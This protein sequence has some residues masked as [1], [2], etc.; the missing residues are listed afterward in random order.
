MSLFFRRISVFGRFPFVRLIQVLEN[1]LYI[2]HILKKNLIYKRSK[3]DFI[4]KYSNFNFLSGQE[5]LEELIRSGKSLARFSD[6]E[7]EMITG[8]GIYPPDSNWSQ[9]WSSSLTQDLLTVLSSTD[10]HLL[11]AVDPPSTFLALRSST[12]SIPFEYNMWIDM[13]R[14]MWKFLSPKVSYGHSHLFIKANSPDFNWSQLRNYF[15]DKDIILAT[16]KVHTLSHLALGQRTFFVECGIKNSYERKEKIKTVIC[17]LIKDNH[18]DKKTTIVLASLGPTACVLAY[19][20][21]DEGIC[22][23][24]SGHMFKL[25]E[26]SFIETTFNN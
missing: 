1:P 2:L 10:G 7:F 14:L 21:L 11:V 23:W 25:A 19:E 4:P 26:K 16:G 12:H 18:L 3:D 9:K 22:V 5:T 20:L 17:N 8:A 15:T 6:G 24:D 13:R